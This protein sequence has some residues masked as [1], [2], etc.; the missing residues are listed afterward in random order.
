MK[1]WGI[2]LSRTGTTSLADALA[3]L[4]YK[5]A[6][7]ILPGD[8][9]Q[10]EAVTDSTVAV[11]YKELDRR[12]PDSKF[13]L[14]VRT[15]IQAWLH[16]YQRHIG[17]ADLTKCIVEWRD[18]IFR[19]RPLLYGSMNYDEDLARSSYFRHLRDVESY[20]KH[21][22]NDLLVMNI[23]AGD[24]WNKLCDFLGRPEPSEAF[25][26]LNQGDLSKRIPQ[27]RAAKYDLTTGRLNL[28]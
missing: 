1:V 14:T 15:D 2:G 21:R 8:F 27:S 13:I 9:E 17:R 7:V 5:S 20:F 26:H 28:N 10:Y 3:M 18:E 19:Y 24:G 4:G 6:H 16:S 12:Y 23:F 22:Q 11:R 25:P